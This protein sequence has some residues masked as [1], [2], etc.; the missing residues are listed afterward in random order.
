MNHHDN[1]IQNNN[2][3]SRRNENEKLIPKQPPDQKI[4]RSTT[5]TTDQPKSD[6]PNFHVYK[7]R[8]LMLL[9]FCL[10]T[11]LNGSMFMGLGS[12][13]DVVAPYYKVSEVSIEWLSN[14]FMVV[15][16]V[17]A[18]PSAFL[19]SKYGVRRV[20]T[21]ASGCGAAGAALQYGG[22][23]RHSY[24]LV[25]AGQFFAAVAYGNII[26]VPG[27]LSAVWFAP[28]ERGIST[29]IGVFMNILGVAIGFVQPAHMI[30]NT[31]NFDEIES[32]VRYF[33]LSKLIFASFVFALT[34]FAF[35]E[36]PPTPPC[37]A[38][39]DGEM[40]EP[41][42]KESLV[43]LVKDKNFMLMAQAY[44]IYYGLYVGVSVVVSPLVLWKH[45]Y[46][47]ADINEQIGWMGFSCNIAAAVSCYVIGIFLDRTSRYKGVAVF[48]NACS[49]LAWCAFTMVLTQT[50]S[51]KGV[52]A[53]YV[54]F[55][56]VGIPYFASGVEQAAEMTFPVPEG[57]SSTVILQLGNMY[58]F[59]L[60]FGLGSLAQKGY[61]IEV[62]FII[63]GLYALSTFLL[64]LAKTE[65]KR[66][67][68]E[69]AWINDELLDDG[70]RKRSRSHY[71]TNG[72]EPEKWTY[73]VWAP[74]QNNSS[75]HQHHHT[76][77]HHQS[78]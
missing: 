59:G 78:S 66:S 74:D 40:V 75:R 16:I 50:S 58:G 70:S 1:V 57:T 2:T 10:T 9:I 27:K 51:F 18:M 37:H 68:S 31:N 21:I 36:Q 5:E 12:V 14:M 30:P 38:Q 60:I 35:K 6:I 44:G 3:S 43:M 22:Y 4:K 11:M 55:G 25:V 45:E 39:M 69:K 33:F 19:M 62:V 20:L 41:G 65:L 32:G 76:P 67:K 7:S 46:T 71:G 56:T 26:Q 63:L 77:K 8:W 64:C 17:V 42:F 24:M 72:P 28:K 52:F 29:S 73:I 34:A 48:L 49:V 47:I 54:V 23:K 15:Y 13:V 61:H 53:A